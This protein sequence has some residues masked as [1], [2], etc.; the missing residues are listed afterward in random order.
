MEELANTRT[1]SLRW[2]R[3][4]SP[5]ALQGWMQALTA[6]VQTLARKPDHP[7]ARSVDRVDR[8]EGV[9]KAWRAGRICE[10]MLSY[11]GQLDR[12]LMNAMEEL[13]GGGSSSR[14]LGLERWTRARQ[15]LDF[16]LPAHDQDHGKSV[17]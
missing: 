2:K 9:G 16:A 15:K 3:T 12:N 13:E 10:G 17:R 5:R 11:I 7:D 6:Q 4:V 8:H 14:A 1:A